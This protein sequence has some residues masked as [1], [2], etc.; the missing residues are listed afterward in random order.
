MDPIGYRRPGNRTENNLGRIYV[1]N[2]RDIVM[3]SQVSSMNSAETHCDGRQIKQQISI[4]LD[5]NNKMV[6]VFTSP[7]SS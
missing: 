2:H 5:L 3:C 4:D 7:E 6:P 1:Q